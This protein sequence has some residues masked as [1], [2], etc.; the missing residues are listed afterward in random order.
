MLRE[1]CF[2]LPN[3]QGSLRV[4]WRERKMDAVWRLMRRVHPDLFSE[5][6][7]VSGY[8]LDLRKSLK[9]RFSKWRYHPPPH[10]PHPT[11]HPLYTQM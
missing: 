9:A 5:L 3:F 1:E 10:T 6:V 8:S 4:G 2:P 7:G 11:P